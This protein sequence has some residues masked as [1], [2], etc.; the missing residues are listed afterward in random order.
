MIRESESR[1]DGQIRIVLDLPRDLD[2]ADRL[3]EEAMGEIV[4]QLN[5]GRRVLLETTEV[6]GKV[7]AAVVDRL[8]AGRRLARAVASVEG[9]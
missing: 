5:A 2:A 7:A 1:T 3:A 6:T 8:S 4:T 9:R